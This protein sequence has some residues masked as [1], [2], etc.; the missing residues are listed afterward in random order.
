M[1]KPQ[2]LALHELT[3]FRKGKECVDRIDDDA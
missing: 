2:R 1:Q 3:I